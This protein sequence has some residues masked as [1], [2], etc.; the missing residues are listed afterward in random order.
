MKINIPVHDLP[1]FLSRRPKEHRHF[2][3][4]RGG[5]ESL[6]VTTQICAQPPFDPSAHGF[7]DSAENM[8]SKF[9]PETLTF[10]LSY[11]MIGSRVLY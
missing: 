8:T 1:S 4:I 6:P 10:D 2:D 11:R 9:L 7:S 5:D 3:C